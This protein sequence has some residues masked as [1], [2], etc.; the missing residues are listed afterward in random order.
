M[1]RRLYFV[2]PDV[3][4]ARTIVDE[5]LL[6]RIDDHHIHVM[7]REDIDLG[8]LPEATLFQK[9]DLIHAMGLGLFLGA[10]TGI[11]AGLAMLQATGI[12]ASGGAILGVAVLGGVVGAWASGMIGINVRN[13]RLRQFESAVDQG[14]LLLMADVPKPRVNAIEEMVHRHHPEAGVHGIEPSIPAFP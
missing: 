14:Q 6:A 9:S 12:D 7:A 1:R 8:D 10:L 5:L 2:L 11:G 13:S 3:K 4:T